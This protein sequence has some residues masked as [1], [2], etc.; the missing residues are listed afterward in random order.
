MVYVF[1]FSTQKARKVGL[2]EFE[3]RTIYTASSIS[4]VYR[5]RTCSNNSSN[6]NSNN[7]AQVILYLFSKM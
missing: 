4:Q 7:D 1:N 3:A 6:N 2:W 5:V